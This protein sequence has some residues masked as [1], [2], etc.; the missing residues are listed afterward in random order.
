MDT[1]HPP[2]SLNFVLKDFN[3]ALFQSMTTKLL[4][5]VTNMFGNGVKVAYELFFF[6]T[7]MQGVAFQVHGL[8]S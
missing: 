2:L 3:S 4:V 8:L 1:V 5:S 7:T 6:L